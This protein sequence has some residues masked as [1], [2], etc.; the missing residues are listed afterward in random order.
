MN[1]KLK[2]VWYAKK[3]PFSGNVTYSK[4][5]TNLLTAKGHEVFFFYFEKEDESE[6]EDKEV[7]L[8]YL[9]KSQA[10][11]IPTVK[12]EKVIYDELKRIKPDIV[13]ASLCIS[14]IDFKLHEI[15]HELNIPLVCTFHNAFDRRPTFHGSAA[16]LLYQLYA[17]ALSKYDG[18]IIFSELQKEIFAKMGVPEHKIK[19]IPNAIDT[20]KFSPNSLDNPE[21]PIYNFNNKKIYTYLGRIDAEKGVDVLIKAFLKNNFDDAVLLIV[22]GGKQEKVL[23]SIYSEEKNI[24]WTGIIKDEKKRINI[25]RNSYSFILPSQIEGLSL[26]LLEAMSCGT[27]CIATDVGADGEVLAK[28]AGIVLN[29]TKVKEQL[30]FSLGLINENKD[31]RN[32]LAKKA[33]ERALESYSIEKNIEQVENLYYECLS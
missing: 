17:P 20:N 8:P 6:K 21:A 33:R 13:H 3:T 32:L 5:I 9:Y 12:S 19:V 25:L 10:Y 14:P 28:G 7:M 24:I 29:P 23:K 1:K 31:F 16:F 22:G 26:A 2:I 11:T 27:A 30:R 4:E 15:C 18:M